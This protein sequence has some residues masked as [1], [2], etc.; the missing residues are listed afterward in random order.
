MSAMRAL[1]SAVVLPVVAVLVVFGGAT[2]IIAAQQGTESSPVL[3]LATQVAEST[4]SPIEQRIEAALPSARAAVRKIWPQWT[5]KLTVVYTDG[6]ISSGDGYAAESTGSNVQFS[7][8]QI[9]T[10]SD[11]ELQALLR[12]ELTHV[13][14]RSFTPPGSANWL[15]EGI[16]DYTAYQAYRASKT[17]TFPV[18]AATLRAWVKSGHLPTA[19]PADAAFAADADNVELAY[20]QAWSLNAMIA[21]KYG[22]GKLIALY[23]KGCA[24]HANALAAVNAVLGVSSAKLIAQW[25]QYLTAQLG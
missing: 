19:L 5:G 23:H 24:P 9:Q 25:R 7:L 12:H 6:S 2:T 13:A 10:L 3:A 16:A 17:L 18:I 21:D 22:Q 14:T 11:I 4:Q 15:V 20:E 8:P 1:I